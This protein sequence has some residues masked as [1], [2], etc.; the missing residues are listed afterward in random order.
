MTTTDE[1]TDIASSFRVHRGGQTEIPGTERQY[2]AI[3][4]AAEALREAEAAVK[5]ANDV[6]ADRGER[7]IYALVDAGV[8]RYRYIDSDGARHTVV[9]T[10]KTTVKV[11]RGW[12]E[13]AP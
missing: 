10:S 9:A 3:E 11:S 4:A 13:D 5:A 8:R 12:T 1:P 2:T 7:L 6:K